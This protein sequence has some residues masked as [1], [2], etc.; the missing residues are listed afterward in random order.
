[1]TIFGGQDATS[2]FGTGTVLNDVYTLNL[3]TNTW[4]GAVS[5]TGA[6]PGARYSHTDVAW[7]DATSGTATM[8]IFGGVVTPPKHM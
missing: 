2:A 6:A 5:T 8:V 1:M 7:T 3:V 4:S